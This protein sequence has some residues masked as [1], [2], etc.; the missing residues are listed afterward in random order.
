MVIH[1]KI[2]VG[3]CNYQI[4]FWLYLFKTLRCVIAVFRL[5]GRWSLGVKEEPVTDFI[6][7]EPQEHDTETG[8]KM[9]QDGL[10]AK[11]P[12]KQAT[13]TPASRKGKTIANTNKDMSGLKRSSNVPPSRK[14]PEQ[15]LVIVKP[16]AE[17]QSD[18]FADIFQNEKDL[19][20]LDSIVNVARQNSRVE[21]EDDEESLVGVMSDEDDSSS[22]G[23]SDVVIV[24]DNNDEGVV[25]IMS[26]SDESSRDGE[27]SCGDKRNDTSIL[28][29]KTSHFGCFLRPFN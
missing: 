3:T 22:S 14:P 17:P 29:N 23:V 18:L 27:V 6:K 12:L 10:P 5:G 9:S 1:V 4:R 21:N 20:A 15:E 2:E 16:V 8:T 26:S 11:K 19:E 13:D 7:T 25:G 28:G 24:G